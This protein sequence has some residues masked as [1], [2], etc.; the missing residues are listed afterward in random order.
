MIGKMVIVMKDR[1]VKA[2]LEGLFSLTILS[3][4]PAIA[5]A[6]EA[7]LK[8]P[9]LSQGQNNL[10][11]WGI[12]VCILGMLFGFYQFTK[13]K[14]IRA[15]QSM[16]DVANTIYETCKTYLIQQGKLLCILF[17]FIGLSIAFYFGFLQRMPPSGVLLILAWTIIGI[18]GSYSVAWYG[19]RMNTLANSRTAFASLEGKP[20]KILNIALDAGMSIG[21]LLVCVE[22]IMM[23]IILLFVPRE[24]AGASFIGFAVGESLGAS[25]LRIAGGIFT[26]I[27]DIGSDLM[28][29]VFGIKEDDPRNPGVI[30]DCT[31][32]NAGD[33]IGPT[34]DGFET[35]GVTGVALVTF[36]VLAV[37]PDLTG[38]LLT[39]IFVMRILMI[40][41][42]ICSFYINRALSQA[43]FGNKDDFDFEQ[44]LTSLVWIT[45]IL[46]IAVTFAISYYLLGPGSAETPAELQNLWLVL[47]IIISC[48]TLGAALIPEFTKIFTSPNSRHVAEVVKASREGGPSLNIL[49]GLV[50]GNF[51]SFWI[52]MVFFA[53]MFVAYYASGHGLSEIMIYPSIFAFGLVA[54]GMLGMGPVNIAVDSYGPVTDNAQSIYELS[55]I[56]TIPKIKEEIQREFGFKPDFDRA[57]HYLEA[58]DGAGNTFK[59][60]AKPVLIG[61]AVVG[62]T[63]MIFSLILV[64]RDVLGV[65]P[66]EILTLLN[67]YTIFGLIAGGAVIY[68][69]T[70]AS[71][72]AVTT[73][74]YRA[75]E[76]IKSNIQLDENAS[77]KAATEKS[78]EVVKICTQ[79]AQQGMFNIFIAIFS[80]T[81]AFSCLSAPIAGND[82]VSLFVSYLISIAVFGL[83]QA[84]FMANAG[85]CWD[86]AKKVV[87]VDL[88]EKGTDLHAA[89]V[90]GDTVGDPFKDTSSVALNPII[91]FTT[92]F[93][94]LAMEIAISELFR[95]MALYVGGA[96]LVV[97]LIFVWRSFYGM[98]IPLRSESSSREILKEPA[99][100]H[101]E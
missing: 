61:T 84:V 98:R 49:S 71:S 15:H 32:D 73:G 80:F 70:G 58:N 30:A 3:L 24:L 83:F 101:Q 63:T 33:S 22:L 53:L 68:W 72:Q 89:T 86:N 77:Q 99:V 1:V 67:P 25:A 45:S 100:D 52:G 18:L 23:L 47:S 19:I 8:I 13:V 59:A 97:A 39:W 55:L 9:N 36:I 21:V 51:S 62:A 4:T 65:Q 78:K 76:Y 95:N 56:E 12:V 27:A 42:S 46:S 6:S 40:L 38:I 20:L 14:R 85:G 93:G 44:P 60:T 43:R 81:L 50:A 10:L 82:S 34:A 74:A 66:E 75:V 37:Q 11:L 29:I 92:L 57:K 16:L 17:I 7:N 5:A 91:K 64:I 96:F 69:F 79:Y 54:F 94:L 87:E 28:K 41:T 88:E 90:V 35:Y 48:G 26:K 31:G 2:T